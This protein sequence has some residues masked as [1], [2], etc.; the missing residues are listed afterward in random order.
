MKKLIYTFIML[1]MFIGVVQADSNLFHKTFETD[2]IEYGKTNY[3]AMGKMDNLALKDTALT[4]N[5]THEN[6]V[7]ESG[8][9]KDYCIFIKQYNN[10]GNI[11]KS[12]I[13]ENIHSIISANVI[14]DYLYMVAMECIEGIE[15]E[16][17]NGYGAI[18]LWKYDSNLELVKKIELNPKEEYN[19]NI[20][21]IMGMYYGAHYGPYIITDHFNGPSTYS[22]DL[23]EYFD[24]YQINKEGNNI[25]IYSSDK[26]VIVDS[27][28]NTINYRENTWKAKY[29][30]GSDYSFNLS[31][32]DKI[33]T[34]GTIIEDEETYIAFLKENDKEIL[35]T[36]DYYSF[37][38]PIKINDYYVVLGLSEKMES[39]ILVIDENGNIIQTITGNYWNLRKVDNGFAV[40]NLGIGVPYYLGNVSGPQ[41]IYTEVYYI[42]KV[43]T[44][45]DGN[46]SIDYK[47]YAD[48][49]NEYVEFTVTPKE[50]YVLGEV[51]VT[52]ANGNIVKFTDYKFSMPNADVLI[53]ATF[54]PVNPNTNSFVPTIF[55]IAILSGLLIFLFESKKNKVV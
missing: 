39:D 47:R 44:K 54:V 18:S 17:S 9:K 30:D 55:I 23:Y 33:L 5:Y 15:N 50:G 45:T 2:K 26:D 10:K 38:F 24:F 46:G 11:I 49:N 19:E 53:E 32:S 52:D 31:D 20:Y 21:S 16:C 42:Y 13:L 29:G 41:T 7:E 1:L 6:E 37:F 22:E 12:L 48:G 35:K 3:I 51:K 43:E 27:D 36:K 8:C 4:V 14:D 28:L 34:S 25:V 40:T